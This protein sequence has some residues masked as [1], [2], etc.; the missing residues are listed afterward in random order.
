[1]KTYDNAGSGLFRQLTVLSLEQALALPFFT[2]RLVQEGM[3]VI[4]IEP[5]GRGDP[6][7]YVGEN[8]LGEEAMGSYFLPYNVGKESITLNLGT[9]EG[10]AI[11][12]SLIARL[13]VDIFACNTRPKN[14][15]K[16]GIDYETLRRIK[17]DLIW[18]GITGFGPDSDDPAYDPILQARAGYMDLTGEPNRPPQLFGLPMADMGVAEHGYGQVM[19][20][21]YRR[22]TLGQG[23]RIDVAMYNSVISWTVIPFTMARSF[24][25]VMTRRGNTHQFYAP[26]SVFPAADGYVFIAVGSDQQWDE[27]TR[28]PGFEAL[29]KEEYRR[30]AGRIA[31][32]DTLNR[33]LAEI[34]KTRSVPELAP[35]F[36]KAGIPF[37]KIYAFPEV[38]VD[39][40]AQRG[41]L[42]SRDPRTG[43]KIEMPP[44][45]VT[46]AFMQEEDM[47]FTFAP[48]LGEQNARIYGE[49]LGY[50][51]EEIDGLRAREVI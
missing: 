50:S 48:R 31:A 24:G 35:F 9:E 19:K 15:A 3:R 11:L 32:V 5:P 49:V 26:A 44:P 39:P 46:T 10:R 42:S 20:A 6:N 16:L 27:L 25:T 22:A 14:Y 1:M 28:M 30:N 41:I 23:A 4:R 45:P 21:L 12:H 29:G 13:P 51:A 8:V 47:T 36:D 38:V 7:R 17:P 2:Y 34:T 43:L 18:V 33:E 37:S 40:L